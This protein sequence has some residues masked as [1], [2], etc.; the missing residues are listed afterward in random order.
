MSIEGFEAEISNLN[1]RR[2]EEEEWRQLVDGHRDLIG[3]FIGTTANLM[4]DIDQII[5]SA[6]TEHQAA[7]FIAQASRRLS[8]MSEDVI[9]LERAITLISNAAYRLADRIGRIQDSEQDEFEAEINALGQWRREDEEWR[10]LI[11][12]GSDMTES[13]IG[14]SA[15]LMRGLG[16]I[17]GSI[18][19]E[20]QATG[21]TERVNRRLNEMAED[22][23]HVLRTINLVSNTMS[24]F[25]DRVQRMQNS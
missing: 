15:N 4:R 14:A 17:T 6:E 19:T 24:G 22:S 23:E 2:Q 11:D 21:L 1:Q 18:K 5:G 12:S 25:L 9:H 8:G 13:F 16:E 3:C 7:G 20:Y 10:I